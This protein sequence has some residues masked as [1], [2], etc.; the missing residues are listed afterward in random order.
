MPELRSRT[1]ADSRPVSPFSAN[2]T[3]SRPESKRNLP[4]RPAPI[5]ARSYAI[6]A[7]YT[8]ADW[9]RRSRAFANVAG[10]AG[11]GWR[12]ASCCCLHDTIDSQR[13]FWARSRLAWRRWR[14]HAADPGDYEYMMPTAGARVA[15]VRRLLLPLFQTLVG[16]LPALNASCL[17]RATGRARTRWSGIAQAP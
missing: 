13:H 6:L 5:R 2:T 4:G 1:H 8:Y 16:H 7:N 17:G 10:G 11:S 14:S 9:Y 3:G 12:I 15:V